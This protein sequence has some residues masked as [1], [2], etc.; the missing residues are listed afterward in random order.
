MGEG[1]ASGN[2]KGAFVFIL[3]D[4]QAVMQLHAV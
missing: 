4:T 2:I 3:Q 1:D